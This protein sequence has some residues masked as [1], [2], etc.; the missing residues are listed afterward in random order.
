MRSI[1]ECYTPD[2]II[3]TD[4]ETNSI[5]K[6]AMKDSGLNLKDSVCESEKT[7]KFQ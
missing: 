5:D 3:S 1:H 4:D 2:E 6:C 7:R